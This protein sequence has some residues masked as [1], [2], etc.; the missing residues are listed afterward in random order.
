MSNCDELIGRE[1]VRKVVSWEEGEKGGKDRKEMRG[2]G[3]ETF[4][5]LR[6]TSAMHTRTTAALGYEY[7]PS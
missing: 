2:M 7:P 6:I 1:D 4:H 5:S 3:V